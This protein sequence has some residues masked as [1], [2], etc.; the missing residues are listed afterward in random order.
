MFIP[1]S[2]TYLHIPRVLFLFY[3]RYTIF[4]MF[5]SRAYPSSILPAMCSLR[6][7]STARIII[8]VCVDTAPF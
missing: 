7:A 3:G 5:V 1:N 4:D 2:N 6:D 8:R